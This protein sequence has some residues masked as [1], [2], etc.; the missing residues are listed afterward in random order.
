VNSREGLVGKVERMN[1]AIAMVSSDSKEMRSSFELYEQLEREG[2][3]D[4]I[5]FLRRDN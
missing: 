5:I 3:E 4:R 2:L 1:Y